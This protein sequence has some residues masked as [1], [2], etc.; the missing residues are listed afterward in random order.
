MSEI[1]FFNI[2]KPIGVGAS[3]NP[4]KKEYNLD[5]FFTNLY[6]LPDKIQFCHHNTTS[7]AQHKAL[8]FAYEKLD[9][10]KDD[11]VEQIIGYTGER[12]K[13]LNLTHLSNFSEELVKSLPQEIMSF[14]KE[15]EDWAEEKGYCNIENLAQEY[16]G[17]GAKL[18]Y[19]LTLK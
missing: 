7:Y 11:I 19:L 16:S 4:V 17:I 18:N 8:D 13:N 1:D 3:A 5:R 15:L 12:I 6:F 2:K 9:D 14:A 10:L